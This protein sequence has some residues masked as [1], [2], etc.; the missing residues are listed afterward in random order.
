M[1]ENREINQAKNTCSSKSYVLFDKKYV[2][3]DNCK[4][5]K[6]IERGV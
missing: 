5:I 2:L 1:L 4:H 6:H 3:Q